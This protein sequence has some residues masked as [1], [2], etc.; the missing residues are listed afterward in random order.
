MDLHTH[1]HLT[2]LQTCRF[3]EELGGSHNWT[4]QHKIWG[5]PSCILGAFG[6]ENLSETHSE[7]IPKKAGP[8]QDLR[9]SKQMKSQVYPPQ[10]FASPSYSQPNQKH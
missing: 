1:K 9:E 2:H 10:M 5:P 8:S 6:P 4:E 3:T 7:C